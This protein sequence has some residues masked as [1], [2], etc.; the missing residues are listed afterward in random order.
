M[1]KINRND[2]CLCKSGLKY[3][4]CCMNKQGFNFENGQE[5][6]KK[7]KRVLENLFFVHFCFCNLF[8]Y[9]LFKK[10][11]LTI[12]IFTTFDFVTIT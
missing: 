10:N 2:K 8:C 5:F 3:K 12:N 6:W 11:V 1:N 9:I 4:N 7:A